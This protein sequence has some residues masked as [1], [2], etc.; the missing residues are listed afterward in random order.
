MERLLRQR[1]KLETAI[2]M[3]S[4]SEQTHTIEFDTAQRL[5]F[6]ATQTINVHGTEALYEQ[7]LDTAMA[8][9]HSDFEDLLV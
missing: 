3:P 7:I 1:T 6:V 9:L 4:E 8:V 5:Q 2:E